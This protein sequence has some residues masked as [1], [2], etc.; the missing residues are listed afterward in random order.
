MPTPQEVLAQVSLF[1]MLSKK[2]VA[3]LG[4]EARDRTFP[5]GMVLTE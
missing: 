5:A 1:S 4:R 3:G 2:D